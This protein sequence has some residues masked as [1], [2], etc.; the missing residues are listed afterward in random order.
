MERQIHVI[1]LILLSIFEVWMCYQVLYRT[2]L[3]K[4]YLR[5]WQKVLI[6][7]NII[8]VGILMGINR[9]LIFFSRTMFLLTILITMFC[10]W[11]IDRT[12]A[13]MKMELIVLYYTVLALLDFFCGFIG[14]EI[15]G[16]HFFDD[17]YMFSQSIVQCVLFLIPRV[18]IAILLMKWDHYGW[19]RKNDRNVLALLCAGMLVLL[20]VYQKTLGNMAFGSMPMRGWA[21]AVS[22]I[23]VAVLTSG[24]FFISYRFKMLKKEN[25][26]LLN[27]EEL[28]KK[29]VKDLE[30]VM[31]KNRIQTHDM[32]NHLLVLQE[33]GKKGQWDLLLSYLNEISEEIYQVRKTTW[34]QVE[35][36]DMLL[37]QKKMK[38]ESR[39]IAFHIQTN[40]IGEVSL[41]DTD[42]CALFGNLLDNAIEACEKIQSQNRWIDINIVRKSKMLHITIANSMKEIPMVK[43]G[44]LMTRKQERGQHGYGIKSVQHVVRK[45]HGDFS[46]Q[47]YEKEF[48][49]IIQFWEI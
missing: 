2:V 10:N 36:I 44:K 7:G 24:I 26:M 40:A 23:L 28:S 45:Y 29:H 30:Q 25:E 11:V 35:I 47:I 37:N 14:I 41:T 33:Y 46:Y 39:G 19:Y 15:I 32:K 34:T 49:V 4:K 6:W 20:R 16:Q 21:A 9:K 38:A 43:E 48:I 1:V 3:E 27:L 8:I 17:I 13:M 18:C 5:K 31:E 42:I 22:M 12:C